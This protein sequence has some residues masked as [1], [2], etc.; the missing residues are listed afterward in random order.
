MLSRDKKLANRLRR[1]E[2]GSQRPS[3]GKIRCRGRMEC[4]SRGREANVSSPLFACP[5]SVP[6]ARLRQRSRGVIYTAVGVGGPLET[7]PCCKQIVF[8]SVPPPGQG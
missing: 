5:S 6:T 8:R 4:E 7:P 3:H 2:R 1:R